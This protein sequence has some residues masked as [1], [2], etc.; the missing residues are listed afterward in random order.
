[1]DESRMR[2]VN[3]N[4]AKKPFINNSDIHSS[5]IHATGVCTPLYSQTMTSYVAVNLYAQRVINT[6]NNSDG[7]TSDSK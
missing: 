4:N 7:L 3:K 1:M 5:E 2:S 6:L